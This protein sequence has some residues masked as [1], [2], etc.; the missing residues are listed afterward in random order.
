MVTLGLAALAFAM[1]ASLAFA[2]T[3]ISIYPFSSYWGQPVMLSSPATFYVNITNSQVY[4]NPTSDPHILLVMTETCNNGLT[5]N[6]V[7]NWTEGGTPNST[8]ITNW[9]METF[10][11][12]KVPSTIGEFYT[13]WDLQQHLMTEEPI[14]WAFEDFLGGMSITGTQIPF[15]IT[16]PSTS[17][18]MAVYVLGKTVCSLIFDNKSSPARPGFVVP[19]PATIMA[20][21]MS[22]VALVSYATIRRKR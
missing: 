14:Y 2:T 7:V 5:G 12:A 19:E 22:L 18:R 1:F 10:P 11:S 6:V 16:L 17:P 8:T 21:A 3:T 20:A 4:G 15:T 13:V 9:K